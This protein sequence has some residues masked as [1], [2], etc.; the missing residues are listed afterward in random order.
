MPARI[1]H[2]LLTS[3]R[4]PRMFSVLIISMPLP[5]AA[6]S[7]ASRFWHASRLISRHYWTTAC[8]QCPLKSQCTNGPE[9]RIKRCEHEHVLEAVRQR[10]DKNPQAM[11]QRRETAE[12]PFAEDADGRHPLSGE[13]L[14]EGRH[15]DGT[16]CARL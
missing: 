5:I 2:S 10:L 8:P 3:L 1:D 6:T 14:A 4:R 15:R 12:H 11:R 9:G 13:A 16:A 7:A